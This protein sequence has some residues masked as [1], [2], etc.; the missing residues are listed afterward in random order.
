M[1]A[2]SSASADAGKI[3]GHEEIKELIRL[4]GETGIEEVEIEHGE[5]RV[6]IVGRSAPAQVIATAPMH[7]SGEHA[8]PVMVQAPSAPAAGAPAA[9]AK[10]ADEGLH[11]VK[12]PMVGTFYRASGPEAAPFCQVGDRVNPNS[13][14]CIVEAMKLMNEI[15]AEM[16]G[17]VRKILV[18]NGQPVEYGQP[19]F[20]IEPA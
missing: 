17:T 20:A 12:S 16:S 4:V 15:K 6:R 19:L 8:L 13:V 1:A 5:Y 11:V 3:L 10:P 14:L 2:K 18:E 9:P 7:Q